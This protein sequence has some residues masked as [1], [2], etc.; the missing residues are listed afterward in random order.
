M[1]VVVIVFL[2]AQLAVS[3]TG[4]FIGEAET[5]SA[6]HDTFSRVGDITAERVGRYADSARDVTEGMVVRLERTDEELSLDHIAGDLYQH[7]QRETQVRAAYVGFPDGAY[8]SVSRQGTGYFERRVPDPANGRVIELRRDTRFE[9]YAWEITD[10]VY[11]P[12]ERPWY[13]QGESALRTSWTEPFVLVETDSPAVTVARAARIDGDVTAV[14]G[15]DLSLQTLAEVLDQLPVGEGA[16]AFIL[17]PD[18]TVIAA[19]SHYEAQ[20]AAHTASVGTPPRT[21]D[22]GVTDEVKAMSALDG[23]VFGQ[24]GRRYILERALPSDEQVNWILHLEADE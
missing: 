16:E 5:E 24:A 21:E 13:I 15:A 11:D 1:V 6:A 3:V 12:R 19:P 10:E 2:T 22:I 17:A 4:A 18:R 8:V 7:L 20:I 14:V 23:N 9:V